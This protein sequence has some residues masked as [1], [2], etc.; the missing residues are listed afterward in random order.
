MFSKHDIEKEFNKGISIVPFYEDNL[1][2][3]SINL[4]ASHFAWTMSSGKISFDDN[5]EVIEGD[6]CITEIN[7]NEFNFKKGDNCVIEWSGEKYIILLPFSTTLIETQEVLAVDNFIGGTYHSKVG[8]ASKGIGHIG[9]ML[10]P[11][12]SGHSLVAVHNVS[13]VPI[14]INVGDTFVSVIFY[15]IDTVLGSQN[16]TRN[17]HLEKFAELG[18]NIT[19]KEREFLGQD[20]KCDIH[21]VREKMLKD[22]NYQEFLK[23]SKRRKLNKFFKYI[24]KRNVIIFLILLG[25]IFATYFS[26]KYLDS[27]RTGNPIWVDRFWTV[28]FSGV[29]IWIF[30]KVCRLFKPN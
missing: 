12:F 27:K 29:F 18:I 7:N 8:L 2:E 16:A 28:N 4:S 6:E 22:K 10:G 21:K 20:W 13:D 9:T 26:A 23:D 3:N 24:N 5:D 30:D 1:K 17:G 19:Q 15:R 11:N 14:K 25:G